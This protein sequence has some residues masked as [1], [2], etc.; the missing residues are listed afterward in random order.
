MKYKI[1]LATLYGGKMK[2]IKFKGI[3]RDIGLINYYY[4]EEGAKEI[5]KYKYL[6]NR[7]LI[8]FIVSMPLI[9]YWIFLVGK[10][11]I[12]SDY[13]IIFDLTSV[14]IGGIGAILFIPINLICHGLFITKGYKKEIYYSFITGELNIYTNQIFRKGEYIIMML[15]PVIILVIIPMKLFETGV[16]GTDGIYNLIVLGFAM[17][18]FLMNLDK[19][20]DAYLTLKEVPEEAIIFNSGYRSYY[21]NIGDLINKDE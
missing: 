8:A 6:K 5:T 9:I 18:T 17:A 4:I 14:T 21:I 7:S 2:D 19:V 3:L 15:A 10:E 13:D 12:N 1:Y 20:F 11:I 16:F